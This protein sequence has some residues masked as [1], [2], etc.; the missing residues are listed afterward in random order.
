V[1]GLIVSMLASPAAGWPAGLATADQLSSEDALRRVRIA[2]AWCGPAGIDFYQGGN[3]STTATVRLAG[4]AGWADLAAEI[5]D[6]GRALTRLAISLGTQP[7]L[8]RR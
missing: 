2:A 5:S 6:S 4:P 3:G 8:I 7:G 1:L